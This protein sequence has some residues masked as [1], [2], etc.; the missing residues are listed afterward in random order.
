MAGFGRPPRV[1]T[2]IGFRVVRSGLIEFPL[3]AEIVAVL[4]V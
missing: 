4:R 2:R 1:K 3:L